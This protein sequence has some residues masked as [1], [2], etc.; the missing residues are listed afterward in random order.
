MADFPKSAQLKK[1]NVSNEELCNFRYHEPLAQ[2]MCKHSPCYSV[3]LNKL[4]YF[5]S[6]HFT[7]LHFTAL[8]FTV[9]LLALLYFTLLHFT[10]LHFTSLHFTSLHFT[11]LHCTLIY[12]TFIFNLIDKA[13]AAQ[14]THCVSDNFL[15]QILLSFLPSNPPITLS[16]ALKQLYLT[17][18]KLYNTVVHF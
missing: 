9:H 13:V 5:T 11:S 2:T 1:P 17:K 10:S 18:R 3:T 8:H 6:L 14:V 12:F 4:L 15:R 16:T 7:S